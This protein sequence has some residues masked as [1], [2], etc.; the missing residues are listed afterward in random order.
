MGINPF[1]QD[2]FGLGRKVLVPC[3]SLKEWRLMLLR[4]YTKRIFRAECNPSFESLHCI[5]QL[6]QDVSEALPFLNASLGGFT[7]IK[8][9][10]SVTF[11]VHGKLITVYGDRIA[12][13]ALKDEEEADKILNWLK[14]EINEAWEK[15]I[16]IQP[17]YE[18]TP[19]P[20]MMEILKLLPRQRGCRACGQPSCMVFAQLV[21]DGIK[22][23]EDC[24][25]MEE[26]A[27][28][29]A[30]AYLARFHFAGY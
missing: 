14:G 11:R 18:S 5:A 6:D 20:Q 2:G 7:Y 10:P 26:E 3:F 25:S 28:Q 15:R 23:P 29:K 13:N 9:P 19:Q 16:Q 27:R 17:S 1:G 22:G 21:A 4:G 8:D 30:R 24:P 12:V